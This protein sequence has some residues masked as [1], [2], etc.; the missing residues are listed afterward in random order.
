M[1][2]EDKTYRT[3]T[4]TSASGRSSSGDAP[5][6][7]ASASSGRASKSSRATT[8]RTAS[9][10]SKNAQ[11]SRGAK[12]SGSASN[13]SRRSASRMGSSASS[14]QRKRKNG[15]GVDF[16]KAGSAVAN[17]FGKAFSAIFSS[18]KL[19]IAALVVVVLLA[20]GIAD[21]FANW[22]KTY[23][24]VYVAGVDVGGLTPEQVD[25]KLRNELATQVTHAQV[26]V[27]ASEDA[28]RIAS[29]DMTEEERVKQIEKIAQ[30]EQ[31]SVEQATANVQSW[32]TDAL[33]L[34]AS[35]PYE[36]L[37][38]DAMQVGRSN[39]FIFSRLGLF[40][41]KNQV[42]IALDY[43]E[44][45]VESLASDIDRT[46]GDAR[47]DATVS[48]TDGEA[49]PVEGHDGRMVDR[50]WLAEQLTAAFTSGEESP[51][52]VAQ[53]TDAPSRISYAE[54]SKMSESINRA[55]QAGAVF[56]YKG[57]NWT[58]DASDIG[59]WTRVETVKNDNGSF[60]L[61]ARID[62]TSAIP[63]V[64]SGAGAAVKSENVIVKYAKADDGTIYVRTLGPGNIPEVTPAIKELSE[65]LYGANGIAWNGY[66]SNDPVRIEIVETDAPAA[67]TVDQAIEMGIITVIGEYTTEFSNDEG[68]ENR[69]HNI[70]LC[71]DILDNGII[72]AGDSWHFNDRTGDTN[73]AAG[74]WA[75]GSIVRG[76]Y[77]DSIGGGICQVATTVFNAVFEGGLPIDMRFPHQLYIASYPNGRDAAVSY[78]D[79]DLW[80]SNDLQSDILLDMSYTDTSIT[81]K[82]Y[83][84]YTG[85]SIDWSETDFSEGAK[86]G[87]KFEEDPSLG[88]DMW[89]TQTT[90]VNGSTIT[91]YRTVKDESG[92]V[93]S[94]QTFESTYDPKDAEVYVGPGSD[95]KKVEE[96][97]RAA[98]SWY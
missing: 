40:F 42:P 84:V 69:N 34:K 48:I 7:R 9:H 44:S 23:G 93:I 31:I 77:V 13:A 97:V 16:G 51:S 98:D 12:S 20:G 21:T 75:A 96:Q 18:K 17:A 73:E 50:D 53:V 45:A 60:E 72:R 59:S 43:D 6:R 5:K 49:T 76:E 70:K 32:S 91:V 46:I 67:L 88:K 90:G 82:L 55:L 63:A 26:K 47:I 35:V 52:F 4:R 95:T 86:Y 94:E 37:V 14:G 15:S 36:K 27:F 56:S 3:R 85:R 58:A 81:A 92:N 62:E 1:A 29:G 83:S 79:L 54:A 66:A 65:D 10:A 68:T 33:T 87:I 41:M 64:V 8:K 71:A 78:P 19:T 89:W 28:K 2:N 57:T 61:G 30:A 80:W 22:G 11:K 38:D 39:G 24:N 74:F 25:E